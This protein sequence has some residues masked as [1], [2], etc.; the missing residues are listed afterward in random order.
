MD[1]LPLQYSYFSKKEAFDF[2]KAASIQPWDLVKYMSLVLLCAEEIESKKTHKN[3]DI[4]F[5]YRSNQETAFFL[6]RLCL[7]ALICAALI[8]LN[9][10][11]LCA[12]KIFYIS[13]ISPINL[14]P[15][16]FFADADESPV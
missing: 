14:P 6:Y 12:N 11:S 10:R 4:V 3:T 5:S 1:F 9:Q 16:C 7:Y 15:D 8:S 2:R 13:Y